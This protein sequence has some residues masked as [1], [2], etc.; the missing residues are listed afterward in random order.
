MLPE[1]HFFVLWSL[2][3]FISSAFAQTAPA[4]A[5]S[6]G[7]DIMSSLTGMLPLVQEL[8]KQRKLLKEILD[9]EE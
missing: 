7:S 4:A 1:P 5:A 3:V 9:Q 8:R 2:S 6:G